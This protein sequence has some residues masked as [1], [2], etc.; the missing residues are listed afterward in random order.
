[1]LNPKPKI[2][3]RLEELGHAVFG[4][5]DYDLNIIGCRKKDGSTDSFDDSLTVVYKINGMWQ[6]D[7]FR[8]TTDPG[9]HWLLHPMRVEGTAILC[10]GQ[11]RSCYK[12]GHH[13]GKYEALVQ[14]GKVKVF[15]DSSKDT[16]IDMDPVS[17]MEGRFGINIHRA[18]HKGTTQRVDKYSAG[19]Q[20]FSDAKDFNKFMLLC[21]K[22][23][24]LHGWDTFTYTLIEE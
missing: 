2:L 12:I 16:T 3:D 15:R 24:D 11:Y 6:V 7:R 8:I 4:G 19:C 22:Q 9:K 21:K 14:R 17:V 13:R 23:K 1:M 20:V 18:Y 5:G 10:P